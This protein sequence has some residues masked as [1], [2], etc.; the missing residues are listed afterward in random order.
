[1]NATLKTQGANVAELLNM[2]KAYGLSDTAG[3]SGTGKLNLDVQVQGTTNN[4][5][6][7][8]FSGTGSLT[9]ATVTSPML[10]KPV[11]V[12]NAGLRFSQN[13]AAID[14][15]SATVG[16]TSLQ[17]NLSANNFAAPAV[18]FALNANSIDTDELQNLMAKTPPKPQAKGPATVSGPSLFDKMTGS[19]T[20]AA[21]RVKAQDLILTNV[22]AT[23]KLDHGVV[24]LSP[25][26]SSLFGGSESGTIAL[27]TRPAKPLCSA[28]VKLAGV[29]TNALLSAVS[30]VKNTLYG[31]LTAGADLSF[32]LS[33]GSDLARTL[34]GSLSFNVDKGELKNI[35]IMGE[36][37]KVGKFLGMPA[38]SSG[39]N[40]PLTKLSGS[41]VVK[42]GEATTTN[43]VA[44]MPSGSFAGTG[45]LNLADQGVNMHVTAA[46]ASGPSQ[47][48][49][50][51]KAGG[52]L[53]TVLANNKGE[54]VVPV[55]VTGTLAHPLFM[56][57][58]AN[59][60]KMKLS[61]LLPTASDP[62]KLAGGVLGTNGVGG[63]INGL[64]GGN[65]SKNTAAPSSTDQ[66]KTNP[67]DSL[68]QQFGKKKPK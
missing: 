67:V 38:G 46:L 22:H 55:I 28:V 53:T 62:T 47:T 5:S 60:A 16:S 40:T 54:L 56:P 17:G 51:T 45:S 63:V 18:T 8:T 61:S 48:A 58:A 10:T 20:L 19:G 41:F 44:A 37:S 27:D 42:S 57:D 2:A 52:F 32:E 36:I 4:P 14:S 49:G 50:G 12:Q 43:L 3:M 34:N 29:D 65:A 15:L 25:V 24:R 33:S 26:T 30:S 21:G 7:M 31:V 35:N 68:L 66:Q 11:S 39:S 1:M 59:L 6:K 23:C 13:S 9:N 64:L